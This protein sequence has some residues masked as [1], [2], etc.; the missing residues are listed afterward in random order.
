MILTPFYDNQ[1][2][3][4]RITIRIAGTMS[5][6]GKSWLTRSTQAFAQ[7]TVVVSKGVT[8]DLQ[9]GVRVLSS[10]HAHFQKFSFFKRNA[11]AQYRKFVLIAEGLE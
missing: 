1:R 6:G 2:T 7:T 3:L 4:T 11:R 8:S 5:A 9:I 10:E